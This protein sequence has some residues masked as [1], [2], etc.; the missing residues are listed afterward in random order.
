MTDQIESY[1]GLGLWELVRS[2][3]KTIDESIE[4]KM[5]FVQD[6]FKEI[7]E[8]LSQLSEEK[9]PRKIPNYSLVEISEELLGYGFQYLQLSGIGKDL[10]K[11][12]NSTG[13][14]IDKYRSFWDK[15]TSDQLK[16]IP[17]RVFLGYIK[18]IK[19]EIQE[20]KGT[21]E[22]LRQEV[23]YVLQ[24]SKRIFPYKGKASPIEFLSF[25]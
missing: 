19:N 10:S 24:S 16:T 7:K 20:A 4:E 1:L 17:D 2:R 3:I 12:L 9:I 8:F 18:H 14:P 21:L 6:K 25:H 22:S 5:K 13:I 11:L 23:F 15:K